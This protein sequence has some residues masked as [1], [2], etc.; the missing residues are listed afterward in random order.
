MVVVVSVPAVV[1][2][3]GGG[4]AVVGEGGGRVG[5]GKMEETSPSMDCL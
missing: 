1:E 2:V 5:R 3:E 4:S